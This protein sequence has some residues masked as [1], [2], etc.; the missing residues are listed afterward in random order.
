MR[1]CL[2]LIAGLGPLMLQAQAR[3]CLADYLSN[4]PNDTL[5]LRYALPAY[6]IGQPM[7]LSFEALENGLIKRVLNS[8][9]YQSY[10]IDSLQ[11]WAI[12][13]LGEVQGVTYLLEEPLVLAPNIVAQGEEFFGQTSYTA[14]ENG[15]RTGKGM[16][17]SKVKIQGHDSTSSYLYNFGDCLVLRT[18]LEYH[19]PDG[20]AIG[21]ELKQWFARGVGLVKVAGT[22]YKKN[23]NGQFVFSEKLAALLE[24]AFIGGKKL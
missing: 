4:S 20:V 16:V 13:Q 3:Y 19:T 23:K 18:T 6:R 8:E 2:L 5:Q 22:Q 12:H 10:A 21:Q 1:F 15:R 11:G 14:L 17:S 7:L 24:E 9:T